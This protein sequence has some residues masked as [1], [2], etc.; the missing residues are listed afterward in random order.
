MPASV[1]TAPRRRLSLAALSSTIPRLRADIAGPE[2][3]H[4]T[5]LDL[6]R[7]SIDAFLGALFLIRASPR[8][9]PGAL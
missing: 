6:G 5:V 2:Q 8:R 3:T 4:G 7:D 1:G 9:R